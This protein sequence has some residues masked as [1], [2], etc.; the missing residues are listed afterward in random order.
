MYLPYSNK[1]FFC[2]LFE[3]TLENGKAEE[4]AQC[5]VCL[6][7]EMKETRGIPRL[8]RGIGVRCGDKSS[9]RFCCFGGFGG[10]AIG[11]GN[12]DWDGWLCQA[13]GLLMPGWRRGHSRGGYTKQKKCV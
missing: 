3:K 11:G 12:L 1:I 13:S 8:L 2:P 6:V 5:N 9:R 7:Q 4:S 10:G